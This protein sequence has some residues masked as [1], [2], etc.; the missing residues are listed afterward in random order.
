MLAS[1]EVVPRRSEGG[2]GVAGGEPLG[3]VE[4]LVR[5]AKLAAAGLV[6]GDPPGVGHLADATE[7]RAVA[8]G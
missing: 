8:V 3:A 4:R 5:P 2:R 1:R 7:G 6:E